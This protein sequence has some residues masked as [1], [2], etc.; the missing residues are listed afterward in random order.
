MERK[1]LD[2]GKVFVEGKKLKSNG[3]EGWN[4]V[5]CARGS[6]NK[7]EGS[8]EEISWLMLKEWYEGM[9]NYEVVSA[10]SLCVK[11]KGVCWR[12]VGIGHALCANE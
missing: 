8:R 2:V 7:C 5:K 1:K 3:V 4:W 12:G 11:F 6:V 10:R 9:K